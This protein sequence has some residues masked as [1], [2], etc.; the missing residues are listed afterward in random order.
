M[1]D[2]V[3]GV[4]ACS[5]NTIDCLRCGQQTE[6]RGSCFFLLLLLFCSFFSFFYS[7]VELSDSVCGVGAC[8]G[9]TIDCLRCGQQTELRG[10]YFCYYYF[11]QFFLFFNSGVELSDS[12][13]G[14]GA[15][16]G[17]TIDCLRGDQRT[18]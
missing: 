9:N 8:S 16:S 5:G 15:C 17:N 13:C 1:F 14:V 2:N 18:D 3:C 12:V 4:G 6:L 11:L 7:G 10:S